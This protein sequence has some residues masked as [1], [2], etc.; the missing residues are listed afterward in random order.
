M[1]QRKYYKLHLENFLQPGG[2]KRQERG[3]EVAHAAAV[4]WRECR[5]E[6][7]ALSLEPL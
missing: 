5:R 7:Y 6:L 2:E 3:N 4:F 1:F